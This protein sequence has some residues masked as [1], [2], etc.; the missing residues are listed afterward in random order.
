MWSLAAITK[1]RDDCVGEKGATP[2]VA[3]MRRR[4]SRSAGAIAIAR[5]VGAMPLPVRRKFVAHE[6]AQARERMAH[7][8]LAQVEPAAG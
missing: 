3:S 7:G 2:S 8:R 5:P 6:F 4:A 1:R